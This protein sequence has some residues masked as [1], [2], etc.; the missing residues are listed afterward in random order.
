MIDVTGHI[1]SRRAIDGPPLVELELILGTACLT[2]ISLLSGNAPAAIGRDVDSLLNWLCRKQTEPSDRTANP[3]RARR[4]GSWT[5]KS[6][7]ENIGTNLRSPQFLTARADWL[8]GIASCH[9]D[10]RLDEWLP[11]GRIKKPLLDFRRNLLQP[12]L[13]TIS[14]LLI[15]SDIRL[16]SIYLI[17]SSPKLL[18]SGSQLVRKFLSDFPRLSEVCRSRVCHPTNQPEDSIPCAVYYFG[19][20]TGTFRIK[21][22]R[23]S[24]FDTGV[25]RRRIRLLTSH[26]SPRSRCVLFEQRPRTI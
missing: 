12:F 6:E 17:V 8:S 15:V 21:C 7:L 10:L 5:A 18:V 2:P 1:P 13:G 26:C 23:N 16:E 25:E 20:R 4:H 19:F 22:I 3:K 11:P 14:P 24:G 9:F